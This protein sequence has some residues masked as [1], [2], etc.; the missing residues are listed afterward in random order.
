MQANIQF[1]LPDPDVEDAMLNGL[2]IQNISK[3]DVK[4]CFAIQWRNDQGDVPLTIPFYWKG[5]IQGYSWLIGG[6]VPIYLH[7]TQTDSPNLAETEQVSSIF[8]GLYGN[9]VVRDPVFNDARTTATVIAY[10]HL[11]SDRWDIFIDEIDTR[12]SSYD[13]V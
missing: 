4:S 10:R 2:C 13:D 11:P 12:F 8:P 6:D 3:E 5:Y 1:E 9:W 7:P